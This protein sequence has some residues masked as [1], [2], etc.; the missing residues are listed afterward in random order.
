MLDIPKAVASCLRNLAD[1]ISTE[2]KDTEELRRQLD[3][4][5]AAYLK[6]QQEK[7]R[8]ATTP[9]ESAEKKTKKRRRD[10]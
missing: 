1:V 5:E 7:L 8:E 2:K 4:A 10:E 6:I 3:N 9:G